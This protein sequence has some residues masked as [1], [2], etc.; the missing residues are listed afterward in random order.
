MT[1]SLIIRNEDTTLYKNFSASN[2]V[3]TGEGLLRG[4]ICSTTSSGTIQFIDGISDNDDVADKATATLT[5]SGAMIPGKHAKTIITSDTT[6]ISDGDIVVIGAIT[7][8]FKDTMAQAY[9]VKRHGTTAATTLAN[10]KAAINGTGTAGVEW[11]AGTVAHSLVVAGAINATTIALWSRIPGTAC[12]ALATTTT[13]THLSFEATTFGAGTAGSVTGVSS[14][15]ATFTIGTRVYTIVNELSETGGATAVVDQVLYGG[16]EATMLDNIKLAIN[17]GATEGVNYS[18]GTVV[19]A[20]VTAE[21]NTNTTQVFQ[22]ISGGIAGNSI[23]VAETMANHT[24]GVGVT[25]LSGGLEANIMII[26]TITP[27]AGV[28]YNFPSV[29]F[30]NGLQIRITNTLEGTVFYK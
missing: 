22:A 27:T 29:I 6:E 7:Y 5:S 26:E 19:N 3:K 1:D 25:T 13:A 10:L 11:F 4:F 18:T 20:L 30:E 23:A 24:F 15:A 21:T 12:N 16:N 17:A 9:D 14:S 8:R 2:L 28:M